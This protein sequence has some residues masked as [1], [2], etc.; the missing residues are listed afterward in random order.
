MKKKR[1]VIGLNAP[2]GSRDNLFQSQEFGQDGHRH[3]V[4]FQPHFQ[5]NMTSQTQYC[6]TIKKWKC[7]ISEVFCLICLK[8]CRLLELGKEILLHFKFCCYGNQ[9]QDYCLL[10]KKQKVYCLS[11]SDVWKVIWNNTVW[12]LLQV[13][14]SFEDKWVIHSSCCEKTI[15]ICFWIKA[16]YSRL[17]CHS[18]EI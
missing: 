11:K 13:V 8:R 3:F 17:S 6:K 10:L 18:N 14:S 16:N 5:L 2:N 9:N 4:S 1:A 12:L 7:N 15:V